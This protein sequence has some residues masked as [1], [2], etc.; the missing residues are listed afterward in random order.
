M[1]EFSKLKLSAQRLRV[2]GRSYGEIQNILGARIPKSTLSDWCVGIALP[3]KDK[4]RLQTK[5]YVNLRKGRERVLRELREK[6]KDFVRELENT[7]KTLLKKVD[8]DTAKMLLAVLYLGEGAKRE[9]SLM[10][11]SSDPGIIILFLNLLNTCYGITRDRVKCRV[12]YRVDQSIGELTKYWAEITGVIAKSFYK[13]IPDART[14]KSAT[15]KVDYKGVCVVYIS[16][17]AKVHKELEVVANL[18]MGKVS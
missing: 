14:V 7:N 17:S 4:K 10:L 5:N 2:E 9:G 6:K 16:D 12:S 3:E 13:T 15:K 1:R 18:L 11:G 8:R